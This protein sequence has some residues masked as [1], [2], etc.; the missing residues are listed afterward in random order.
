MWT[1]LKFVLGCC[2]NLR[3]LFNGLG[4]VIS[5][6]GFIVL[7]VVNAVFHADIVFPVVFQ[8]HFLSCM[9]VCVVFS[10]C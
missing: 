4:S 9:V 5:G 10:R 6:L 3:N 2:F 8:R 1:F 7:T